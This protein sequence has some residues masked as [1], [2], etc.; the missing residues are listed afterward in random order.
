MKSDFNVAATGSPFSFVIG[1]AP[2]TTA[3]HAR[4][5][6]PAHQAVVL[7]YKVNRNNIG[8]VRN[9]FFPLLLLYRQCHPKYKHETE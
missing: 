8:R 1:F 4:P 5:P 3:P 6:R 9:I 2:E 7:I